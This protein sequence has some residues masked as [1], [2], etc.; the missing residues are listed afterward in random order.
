MSVS[1][2]RAAT[3]PR[4]EGRQRRSLA[5]ADPT[6]AA[7]C[8]FARYIVQTVLIACTA[9]SARAESPAPVTGV[10]NAVTLKRSGGWC[11]F[12]GPRAIVTSGDQLV[13]TSI[14]GDTYAGSDAG[15]LWV[16]TWDL[17]TNRLSQFQLHDRLECDDH[18]VAA[19]LQRPDGRILAVYGKHGSDTLQRWRITTNP[20][21][22]SSWSEE[23][24]FD[25]GAAYTYSNLVQLAAEDGRIYNFSRTRGY[26]PNC[27]ISDDGGLTWKYGW[28]LIQWDKAALAGDPRYT[29]VDGSRPYVR[30]AT[31]GRGRIHFATTDD[32]PRAYDNSV[33]HGYYENGRLHDSAGRP[34][35]TPGHAG[36]SR[37]QPRSFTEVF[38]GDA[39]HVAWT[40]D[41]ELDDQGQPYTVFS[42]QVDGAAGRGRP[43]PRFGQDHRYY[44]ARWTAGTWH[45][46][47]MAH[48]GTALYLQESDYTGLAALDPRDPVF[49]VISTNAHPRTGAPLVSK[50]D[51]KRHWELFRGRTPDDGQTWT[52]TP[53]TRDSNVDNLRPVIPRWAGPERIILWA[54]GKLRTYSDYRLDITAIRESR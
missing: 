24:H 10:S 39:D 21:D 6:K 27:T 19:L 33:Y 32:H 49:V 47:E 29:L 41:L 53:I 42:V 44:Y 46:S 3:A 54:R 12:Q 16:T 18:N 7:H 26:N 48:A 35:G 38:Q 45:V 23:A 2:Q 17:P 34:V 9:I 4:T 11:W 28:R 1:G 52:W 31:D 36:H 51:G 37:L 40:V 50:T 14:A 5:A 20:G 22:T 13:F 25:T 30:Y 43:D 8:R 15:D